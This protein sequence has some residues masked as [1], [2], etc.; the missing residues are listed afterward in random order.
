MKLPSTSFRPAPQGG[1]AAVEFAL[2]ALVFFSFVYSPLVGL[3][4]LTGFHITMPT[5][6][7]VVVAQT[8]GKPGAC[9]L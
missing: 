2:V 8:L 1:T 7:T 5:F 3:D 6:T 9:I 4:A